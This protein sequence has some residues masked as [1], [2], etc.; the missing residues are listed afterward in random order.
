M[1]KNHLTLAATLTALLVTINP[2]APSSAHSKQD[3]YIKAATAIEHLAPKQL[4]TLDRALVSTLPAT[5]A[6]PFKLKTSNGLEISIQPLR[7]N[8]NGN[9]TRTTK[10]IPLYSNG[11][12]TI[13]VP[14]PQ[15]GNGMAIHEVILNKNAPTNFYYK[16]TIPVNTRLVKAAN[17]GIAILNHEGDFIAAVAAPWAK[18]S[19][20]TAVPTHFEI[21][22]N[23]LIQT[24]K[25]HDKEFTYPIVA[26]P[27][28]GIDVHSSTSWHGFGNSRK[29]SLGTT[30]Q[31]AVAWAVGQ[32]YNAGWSEAKSKMG[33][34]LNKETYR[35]QYKCHADNAHLVFA[36]S[37]FG[38]GNT[39]DLEY[40]RGT[41]P[42]YGNVAK[43]KCNW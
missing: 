35:Q 40:A 17:G 20:D 39:W 30:P 5:L 43:H 11:D 6:E 1:K 13:T 28:L 32:A 14:L 16:L 38:Y 8:T 37:Q 25:H 36:A 18:D 9:L 42:D 4:L 31:M 34:E 33:P 12:H 21:A 15:L 41:N 27:Y 3:E 24:V 22:G 29:A 26:D 7:E 10:N 2:L 19:T 23:L